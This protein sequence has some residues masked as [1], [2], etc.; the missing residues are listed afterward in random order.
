VTPHRVAR[1]L[2]TS[3]KNRK[4]LSSRVTRKPSRTIPPAPAMAQ[5]A[6][7]L[8]DFAQTGD[9]GPDA[10]AIDVREP[11]QIH[12]ELAPARLQEGRNNR[13]Q[14]GAVAEHHLPAA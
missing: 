10:R 11:A 5:R 2:S 8:T 14:G 6:T 1:A 3:G 9:E 13:L 4:T 12:N 7:G